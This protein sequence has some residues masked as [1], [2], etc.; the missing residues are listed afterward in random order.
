MKSISG[1]SV[2]NDKALALW[3]LVHRGSKT[4][5][6]YIVREFDSYDKMKS[7]YDNVEIGKDTFG[8]NRM[9]IALCKHEHT[10][11]VV[12]SGGQYKYEV[13]VRCNHGVHKSLLTKDEEELRR[14]NI[15]IKFSES[16]IE[17]LDKS[18]ISSKRK[19]EAI[20]DKQIEES[21]HLDSLR[22][23]R[24]EAEDRIGK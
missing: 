7:F 3:I 13:C 8:L 19:I 15:Q 22:K 6:Y 4:I 1:K 21:L 5:Q 20:K 2:V 17:D 24:D 18:I 9:K 14:I 23:L 12:S 10:K 16:R 11:N